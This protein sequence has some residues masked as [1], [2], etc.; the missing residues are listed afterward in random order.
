MPADHLFKGFSGQLRLLTVITPCATGAQDAT[1][2][3]VSYMQMNQQ[4]VVDLNAIS[5]I[6]GQFRTADKWVIID[7]TGGLVK[8]E[9]V[10]AVEVN[11]EQW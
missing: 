7:R 10:P 11:D 6:V 2:Q 1:Q 3:I 8:P 4:L 5:A 9:F